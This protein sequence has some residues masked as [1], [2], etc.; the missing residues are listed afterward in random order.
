[1]PPDDQ[2]RIRHMRDA[3]N[4]ALHYRQD[5]SR[6]GL[7]DDEILR[8][9]VTKL[10]EIVGEAA[11]QVSEPT[12]SAHPAVPWSAAAPM[13]DRLTH[14]YFDVDL[15]VLWA[16]I[17]EDFPRLL[18]VLPVSRRSTTP[19]GERTTSD[20]QVS[21]FDQLNNQRRTVLPNCC[22]TPGTPLHARGPRRTTKRVHTGQSRF[23]WTSTVC[24]GRS[25][26][27]S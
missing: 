16:T 17:T 1:M 12:R 4:N 5:S 10:V 27:D 21:R 14:H 22:L 3:V 7:E 25:R 23:Q 19:T 26:S 15:D 9:A 6:R 11:K 8:L 20:R 24:G 13:R 2:I 18:D